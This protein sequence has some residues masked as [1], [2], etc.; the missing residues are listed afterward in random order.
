MNPKLPTFAGDGTYAS[1]KKATTGGR[2]VCSPDSSNQ[3]VLVDRHS[4]A[5]NQCK[6]ESGYK[7]DAEVVA[8]LLRI[9]E[10]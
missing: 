8:W 4:Q 10:G 9:I 3:R 1:W 2:F 5:M 7:E 6:K